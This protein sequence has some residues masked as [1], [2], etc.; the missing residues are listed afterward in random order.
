M[1]SLNLTPLIARMK[2]LGYDAPPMPS[3][4]QTFVSCETCEG[5][6]RKLIYDDKQPMFDE[7]GEDEVDVP[8]EVHCDA[9]M[10]SGQ[11]PDAT[12]QKWLKQ[13]SDIMDKAYGR[14]SQIPRGTEKDFQA[15]E[16]IREDGERIGVADNER[17]KRLGIDKNG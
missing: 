8:V 15:L 12:L 17:R 10:G 13:M 16:Q 4:E 14:S 3:L 9:C 6:G 11:I 2:E 7:E 5:K 1:S